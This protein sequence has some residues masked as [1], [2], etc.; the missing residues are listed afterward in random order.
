L[1]VLGT[2]HFPMGVHGQ[3]YI[4]LGVFG[5]KMFENHCSR[6]PTGES[7]Y[8]LVVYIHYTYCTGITLSLVDKIHN[9]KLA[10]VLF[11]SKYQRSSYRQLV[12]A[13]AG[14]MYRHYI[15]IVI[16]VYIL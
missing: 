13:R 6:L 16:L 1:G 3:I 4:N 8:V 9:I 15:H 12:C 7:L 14:L 5:M 11:L 10:R 2:K